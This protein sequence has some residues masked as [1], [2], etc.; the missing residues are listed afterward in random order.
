MIDTKVL[1]GKSY[2]YNNYN[3]EYEINI[4]DIIALKTENVIQKLVVTISQTLIK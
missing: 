3:T 1:F 4:G 2:D